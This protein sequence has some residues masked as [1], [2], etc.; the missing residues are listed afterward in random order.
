MSTIF[1]VREQ[2][3]ASG[4]GLPVLASKDK[5]KLRKWIHKMDDK[6]EEFVGYPSYVICEI[7]VLE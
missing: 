5:E 3:K 7:E 6:N 4:D 1:V 2:W